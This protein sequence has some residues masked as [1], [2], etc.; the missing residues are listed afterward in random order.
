MGVTCFQFGQ[1]GRL[2]VRSHRLLRVVWIRCTWALFAEVHVHGLLKVR[3]GPWPLS[4]G[5][6]RLHSYDTR[7]CPF[8]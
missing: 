4:E 2:L 7:C 3:K 5:R 6:A 1:R 8:L